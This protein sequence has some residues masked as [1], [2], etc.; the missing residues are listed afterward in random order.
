MT[1][2]DIFLL[3]EAVYSRPPSTFHFKL[4][5]LQ[6]NKSAHYDILLTLVVSDD[7]DNEL[8]TLVVLEKQ[9]NGWIFF[10]L[11]SGTG[12]GPCKVTR[13]RS[14]RRRVLCCC[15]RLWTYT[16]DCSKKRR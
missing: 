4:E 16:C 5:L 15:A 3:E 14:R 7:Y 1:R 2:K 12:G 10:S 9:L 8:Y 6:C 11:I 13:Q